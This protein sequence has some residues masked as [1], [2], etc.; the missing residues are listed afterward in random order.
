M[1]NN[2][3]NTEFQLLEIENQNLLTS[4]EMFEIVKETAEEYCQYVKKY[5]EYTSLYYEKISK[6]SFSKKEVKNKSIKISPIYSIIDKVTNLI[7]QQIE[8]LKQ[9]INSFDIVLKQLEDILKNE[10]NY[11]EE[12]KKSFEESK[13][14]YK[15]NKGKNKKLMD[16]LSSLEKKVVKYQLSKKEKEN[17]DIKENMNANINE[18]KSVEKEFLNINKDDKNY[19]LFFQEESLQSIDKIKLH[20]GSILQNLNTNIIFFL[21]HFNQ[22]YSPSVE[23]IKKEN[24]DQ[25]NTSNLVNDNLILKTFQPEEFPSD[26][27]NI[28]LLNNSEID[29]LS[30]SSD[31]ID[32]IKDGNQKL[33]GFAFFSGKKKGKEESDIIS[34]LTRSDMIEIVKK[35][36]DNF[37]MV[38]KDKFDISIEEEKVETIILTDKLILMKKYQKKKTGNEEI[39]TDEEKKRLFS[40]VR[41]K[42]NRTIFLR[43]VNKLRTYG[44]FEYPKK[45]IDEIIEIFLIILDYILTE[46]DIF[47][48][49]LSII[50]SQTFFFIEN[51]E[52]KYIYKFTKFHKIYHC[53]EM[54]RESLDYFIKQEIEKLNKMAVNSNQS[55]NKMKEMIFAQLIAITNNMLEFDLDTSITEKINLEVLNKYEIKEDSKKIIMNIIETKKNKSNITSN[56]NVIIKDDNNNNTKEKTMEEKNNIEE[57]NKKQLDSIS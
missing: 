14:K 16:S 19:H 35:F 9:F 42:D 29:M 3:T 27:Y 46:K 55:K 20:I 44:K 41:K 6:L 48:F 24:N 4:L 30:D 2:S 47:S 51:N 45:V 36:Y 34:K 56:E 32:Y 10:Q 5:K 37:K 49:Q 15:L 8:G 23:F 43:R 50:L 11:L 39:I 7:T 21:V 38:N 25:I 33:K 54:W 18:A 28:K 26:K 17:N 57:E 13:K 31:D 22:C 53:E 12:P 40:L 52:K 1:N